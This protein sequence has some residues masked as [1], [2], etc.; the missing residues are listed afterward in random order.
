M[1]EFCHLL[2]ENVYLRLR[3]FGLRSNVKVLRLQCAILNSKLNV[4]RIQRRHSIF[5]RRNLP[6]EIL[7]N[8]DVRKDFFNC[9][10]QCHDEP[11]QV[12]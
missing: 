7:R 9:F 3:N 2:F 10:K 11:Q 8:R 4:V 12:A 1:L 6:R 5:Y